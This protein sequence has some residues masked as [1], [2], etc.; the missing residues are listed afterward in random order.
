M[1]TEQPVVITKYG[2]VTGKPMYKVRGDPH[3][4]STPTK[5]LQVHAVLKKAAAENYYAKGRK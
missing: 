1:S 4:M 3:W 2:E 5:A